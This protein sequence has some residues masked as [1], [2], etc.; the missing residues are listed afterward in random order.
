MRVDTRDMV[1][2]GDANT[3]GLS[4]LVADAESGRNVVL[5]RNSRPVAALVSVQRFD[6]L[7]EL[8][9]DLGLF[10]LALARIATDTGARVSFDDALLALGL[11]K[12]DLDTADAEDED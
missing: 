1:A 6:E 3:R 12:E 7:E 4:R 11:S 8:Q 5:I 10:A 2:I 9:E